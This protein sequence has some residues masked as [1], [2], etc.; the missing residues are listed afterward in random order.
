MQIWLGKQILDQK[1]KVE[2]DV[3]QQQKWVVELPPAMTAEQWVSAYGKVGGQVV[4]TGGNKPDS[5]KLK[6]KT[7]HVLNRDDLDELEEEE[8]PRK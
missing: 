6:R 2:Q 8:I 3:K 4:T 5:K 7:A 1:D